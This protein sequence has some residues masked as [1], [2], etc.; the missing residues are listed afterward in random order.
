VP[1]GE[2]DE[3]ENIIKTS[4]SEVLNLFNGFEIIEI[5]ERSFEKVSMDG[6]KKKWHTIELIAKKIIE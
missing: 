1:F 5:K 3:F 2:K 4:K 6:Y